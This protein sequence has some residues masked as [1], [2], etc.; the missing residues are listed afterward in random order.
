MPL[1]LGDGKI[2]SLKTIDDKVEM[3]V[4]V[5]QLKGTFRLKFESK[6]PFLINGLGIEADN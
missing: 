6:K 1:L 2:S 4:N 5:D 3:I